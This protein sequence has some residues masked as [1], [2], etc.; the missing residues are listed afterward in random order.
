MVLFILFIIVLFYSTLYF[1]VFETVKKVLS[2][3]SKPSTK[4]LLCVFRKKDA[5]ACTQ[6]HL[7]SAEISN[8]IIQ[9]TKMDKY[10]G[11]KR[12]CNTWFSKQDSWTPSTMKL[13]FVFPLMTRLLI[14]DLEKNRF[15]PESLSNHNFFSSLCLVAV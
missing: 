11:Q 15:L 2:D 12:H 3:L 7:N 5:C 4:L 8:A 14:P 1:R 6:C 10:A 13:L 9:N